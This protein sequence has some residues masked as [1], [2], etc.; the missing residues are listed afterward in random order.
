M[1]DKKVDRHRPDLAI[2]PSQQ[3]TSALSD[4]GTINMADVAH[5]KGKS[6]LVDKFR[7]REER[8]RQ[9]QSLHDRE[10][11]TAT[12]LPSQK[13]ADETTHAA[14]GAAR[15][16]PPGDTKQGGDR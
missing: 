9:E 2:N 1:A 5:D 3:T 11:A 4:K 14:P 7:Q 6:S 8:W 16:A 13:R 12:P 10:A 15:A